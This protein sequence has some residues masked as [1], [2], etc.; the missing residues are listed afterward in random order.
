MSCKL[1][2]ENKLTNFLNNIDF[3]PQSKIAVAVSGGPDSMA[4]ALTLKSQEKKYGYILYGIHVNHKLRSESDNEAQKVQEWME[5]AN[6]PCTIL[7]WDH[8]EIKTKI[9][10]TARQGRYELLSNAAK[11]QN[12]KAIFLAHHKEDQY[13]TVLYRLSCATGMDGLA[14]IPPVSIKDTIPYLRPF[15]SASKRDLIQYLGAHSYIQDPSNSNDTYTRV[16]FRNQTDTLSALGLTVDALV[17][18]ADKASKNRILIEE[19]TTQVFEKYIEIHPLGYAVMSPALLK[20]VNPEI[21]YRVL[22]NLLMQI[23]GNSKFLRQ[24]NIKEFI[25]KNL[26][27]SIFK[28][29][30]I[31][32]CLVR[33][34]QKK[35]LFIREPEKIRDKKSLTT[36]LFWDNRFLISGLKKNPELYIAALGK[37]WEKYKDFFARFADLPSYFWQTIPAIYDKTDKVLEIIVHDRKDSDILGQ[38][39][40]IKFSPYCTRYQSIFDLEKRITL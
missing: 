37:N 8:P 39:V 25:D 38:N 15:L 18:V 9:Q 29:D 7:D 35:W 1:D 4:L 30:S 21:Q 28:G 23:G 22:E 26:K 33:P 34:Y 24:K 19:L 11:E 36:S 16:K 6:I 3:N 20:E 10:E 32:N 40:K 31:G 5:K 12:I 14:G 27:N 2:L 13:E 17:E